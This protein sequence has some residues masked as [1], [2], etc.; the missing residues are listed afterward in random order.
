MI[1]SNHLPLPSHLFQMGNKSSIFSKKQPK[2]ED[3]IDEFTIDTM[4]DKARRE[5][6]DKDPDLVPYF[7]AINTVIHSPDDF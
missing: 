1:P 7:D 5:L 6:Q 3:N 2:H 4:S